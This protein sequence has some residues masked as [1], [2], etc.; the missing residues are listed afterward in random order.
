MDI[1][2][3][4]EA[5]RDL[6]ELRRYLEPLSPAGLANVTSALEARIRAVAANPGIGRPTPRDDVREAVEA[7]YGFLIP[8]Q[9]RD[10][11]LFVL[12]VYRS[13]RKPLDYEALK[14]RE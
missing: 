3:T 7:K 2:F 10:S 1:I 12:R 5:K 11:R 8:Y 4:E 13:K 14:P 9:A 6:D